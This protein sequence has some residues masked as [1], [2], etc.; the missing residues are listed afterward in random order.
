MSKFEVVE[1]ESSDPKSADF[2]E[3]LVKQNNKPRGNQVAAL[4][5]QDHGID[6]LQ[7]ITRKSVI[8]IKI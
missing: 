8:K 7:N 5:T 2:Y 6:D 3:F 1:G 4:A